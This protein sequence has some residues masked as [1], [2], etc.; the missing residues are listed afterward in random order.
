VSRKSPFWLK[1]LVAVL[2]V[3]VLIAALAHKH[4]GASPTASAGEAVGGQHS[5]AGAGA[6]HSARSRHRGAHRPRARRHRPP[7]RV[8]AHHGGRPC[9]APQ[10]VLAGVYH[11]YRLQVLSSCRSV[12]GTV[13]G[14]RHEQDGDLHIDLD[15]NGALTN[16]VNGAAQ[17]GALVVEF[18]ARDGGHLPAPGLGARIALTG[19]WVLDRDHGWNE[20]HPVWSETLNGRTYHSGPSFGGSPPGIGSSQADAACRTNTGRHCA[21]YGTDS[22]APEPPSPTPA[23]A[24]A[25]LSTPAPAAPAAEGPGSLSHT[26]DAAFCSTHACIASFSDGHGTVVQCADGEWSHSGGLSGAC[27]DHGGERP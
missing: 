15:T 19:A 5:R 6:A 25:P 17:G 4:S 24:P 10:D 22:S 12:S 18:M 3:S 21:G 9:S 26:G 16:A 20:L 13:V 2:A 14:I 1:V 8:A 11:P 23:P 27:S 7:R